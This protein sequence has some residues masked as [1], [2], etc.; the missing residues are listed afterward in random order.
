MGLSI[1]AVERDVGL[2]KD[3]LR[4]WERRYGFPSPLRDANGD[5]IYPP[6]QVRRLRLIKRLT[7][8]G[9]RPGQLLSWPVA[10][11]EEALAP[12]RD[13]PASRPALARS[14]EALGPLM[15]LLRRHDAQGL[16]HL[17]QQRLALEG[18]RR[19]VQDTV[20]PMSEQVGLDWEN[21]QLEVFEEHLFT[22]IATRVLRQAIATVPGGRD[23]RVLLTT[24]THESHNLGLL[25]AE[26]V[27]ALAGAHCLSLGTQTP[28]A[29]IAHAV[30]A[31]DVDVV[32][33]SFSGA[34]PRRQIDPLLQQ[35]RAVLPAGVELWVG[36]EGCSRGCSVTGV[37]AMS[38]L[39]EAVDAVATWRHERPGS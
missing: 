17:L 15:A 11:L 12:Q 27:M 22:D 28:I 33:L 36:G 10:E 32:A 25:M 4:V 6:E 3:V 14:T 37:R 18:L 5:R 1:T 8:Q 20:A 2:S 24:L 31:Y 26:A 21:G 13:A 35:L 16:L 38:S 7:D 39:D 34:F 29:E 30:D 9:H 19:F 23:P